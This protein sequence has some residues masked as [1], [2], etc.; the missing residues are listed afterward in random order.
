T[1]MELGRLFAS[2]EAM[3]LADD[4][5]VVVTADH[6]EPLGD[7][8]EIFHG[9]SLWNELVRVPLVMWVPGLRGGVRV[10]EV[11]SLMDVAPTL[12][13]VAGLAIPPSF[14]G[15]SW[16]APATSVPPPGATGELV[17][18]SDFATTGWYARE[19]PWKA[20]VDPAKGVQ[21]FHI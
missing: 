6:G 19:G 2:L 4:T 7:R 15:R 12:A 8:H 13:D 3:G 16:L 11:V 21:L 1:D 17:R 20:I 14:A 5:V 10:A 9:R 18:G